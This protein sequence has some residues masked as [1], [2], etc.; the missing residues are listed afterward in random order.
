MHR[1]KRTYR[2]SLLFLIALAGLLVIGF[3][4]AKA[5]GKVQTVSDGNAAG[6]AEKEP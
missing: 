6:E 3:S 1:I 2:I 5:A 4:P